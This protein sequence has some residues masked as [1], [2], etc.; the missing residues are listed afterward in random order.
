[1]A[2]AWHW[3]CRREVQRCQPE[4]MSCKEVACA[5]VTALLLHVSVKKSRVPSR[6]ARISHIL[7]YMATMSVSRLERHSDTSWRGRRRGQKRGSR[8][9][10]DVF[11]ESRRGLALF[12]IM[13]RENQDF[14]MGL[15]P[16]SD[17]RCFVLVPKAILFHVPA[18]QGTNPPT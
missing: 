11:P 4:R 17:F 7:E 12:I 3:Y 14:S 1:M 8:L 2:A 16:I 18:Y 10:S 6:F 5:S 13:Q 15:I 9:A